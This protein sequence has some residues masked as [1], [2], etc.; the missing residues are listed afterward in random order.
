MGYLL[1]SGDN[2]HTGVHQLLDLRLLDSNELVSA[3]LTI[4]LELKAD[5][6][7]RIRS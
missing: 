2:G 7:R 3:K 5:R 4:K 6:P 1:V